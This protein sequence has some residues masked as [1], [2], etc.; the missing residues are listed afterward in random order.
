MREA[1]EHRAGDYPQRHQQGHLDGVVGLQVVEPPGDGEAERGEREGGIRQSEPNRS[2]QSARASEK[3]AHGAKSTKSPACKSATVAAPRQRPN[4]SAV[5]E[6]GRP[7]PARGTPRGGLRSPRP[8][9]RENRR[10]DHHHEDDTW[11]EVL[12]VADGR[13]RHLEGGRHAR[14]DDTPEEITGWP[15]APTRRLGWRRNP[16]GSRRQ[17]TPMTA[18]SCAST[19]GARRGCGRAARSAAAVLMLPPCSSGAGQSGPHPPRAPCRSASGRRRPGT[20]GAG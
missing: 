15:K 4:T 5:R 16:I 14:A 9:R 8:W 10:E 12:E 18:S 6:P 7:A 20:G 11:E 2:G 13:A 19:E 3:P 17:R 1:G